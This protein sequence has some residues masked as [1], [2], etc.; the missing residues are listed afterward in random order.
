MNKPTIL[1][2]DDEQWLMQGVV[3][4]LSTSFDMLTASNGDQALNY[5]ETARFQIELII[6]DIMF[7]EGTRIKTTNRGRT[8]GVEFARYLYHTGYTIPVV[9][10]TVVS[11]PNIHEELIKLGVKEIV[12]KRKLP[13]ELEAVIRKYIREN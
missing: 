1:F 6:L 13:S 11:D 2:I 10:Y 5:L 9:C 7:P 12:S 8:S 3:D 4:R